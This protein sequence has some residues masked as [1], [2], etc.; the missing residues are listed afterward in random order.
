MAKVCPD[1]FCQFSSNSLMSMT[2]SDPE[3]GFMWLQQQRPHHILE[4]AQNGIQAS[5]EDCHN[6][7]G[8]VSTGWGQV[9]T[10]LVSK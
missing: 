10:G 4:Y 8:Q 2:I 9:S 5:A 1:T 6:T 3:K 7:W